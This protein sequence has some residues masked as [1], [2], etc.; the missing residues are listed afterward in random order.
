MLVMHGAPILAGNVSSA[1]P[2]CCPWRRYRQN[3][4]HVTEGHARA[5]VPYRLIPYECWSWYRALATPVQARLHAS[6]PAPVPPHCRHAPCFA[7]GAIGSMHSPRFHH[8]GGF[9]M[10]R[11]FHSI[12][13]N[14]SSAKFTRSTLRHQFSEVNTQ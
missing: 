11:G 10:P 2:L 14:T 13:V 3:Q 5:A 8:R 6:T 9:R 7:R 1:G 12:G 4:R